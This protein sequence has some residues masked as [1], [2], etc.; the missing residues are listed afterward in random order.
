MPASGVGLLSWLWTNADRV[1]RLLQGLLARLPQIGDAMERA[2][3]TMVTLGAA[4][5]GG[6]GQTGAHGEVERIRALLERQQAA[7]AAA[8]E[9]LHHASAE[10]A[11]VKV[12][13]VHVGERA[14]TLPLGAGS[15][16]VPTISTGEQSPLQ[17]VAAA[18]DRQIAQLGALD[19][20]LADAARGLGN[21]GALLASTAGDLDGV[22]K[23][24]QERG[25]ELKALAA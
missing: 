1:L 17:G 24:L 20:P 4:I 22:G 11:Q 14:I 8:I 25:G 9:D 12:P 15:I 2:G 16:K 7:L 3:G 19:D 5:Q 10:L 23:L 18:L 6:A 21:L 13:S